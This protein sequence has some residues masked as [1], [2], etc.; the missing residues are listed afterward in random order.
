MTNIY[1]ESELKVKQNENGVFLAQNIGDW[2]VKRLLIE[3]KITP[4]INF[5]VRHLNAARR[6]ESE[7]RKRSYAAKSWQKKLSD[8]KLFIAP[9]TSNYLANQPVLGS[10]AIVQNFLRDHIV[11]LEREK[12]TL[13]GSTNK[14]RRELLDYGLLLPR[15]T[16]FVTIDNANRFLE[17]GLLSPHGFFGEIEEGTASFLTKRV[18]V[19]EILSELK[20]ELGR[21]H[22][23]SPGLSRFKSDGTITHTTEDH[24]QSDTMT[25]E[26]L[27]QY[28]KHICS[29]KKL[30][31]SENG[32]KKI[33]QYQKLLSLI[34]RRQL[35]RTRI[36]GRKRKKKSNL[37]FADAILKLVDYDRLRKTLYRS[38]DRVFRE[39]ERIR[40]RY[41]RSVLKQQRTTS[42]L[43]ALDLSRPE[44]AS[45]ALLE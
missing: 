21:I 18:V 14:T 16:R 43:P 11:L 28:L 19:L 17:R 6:R 36:K 37:V 42:A 12:P 2:F 24:R 44:N 27:I 26:K 32:S 10:I 9:D 20:H 15:A 38:Y 45:P 35:P 22:N 40:K 4:V 31:E 34:D 23:N 3:A 25:I 1:S 13:K 33:A 5:S 39:R 30:K 7:W 8:L 41:A 29:D